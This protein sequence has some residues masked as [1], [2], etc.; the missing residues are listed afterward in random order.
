MRPRPEGR[1]EQRRRWAGLILQAVELQCGHDPKA[2]E[3]AGRGLRFGHVR[4]PLQCGHDP[5]AV[6]NP[7]RSRRPPSRRTGFNAATTRRPWRTRRRATTRRGLPKLQCGH[8]PKAVENSSASGRP[9]GWGRRFNAATTRRPWRTSR[10]SLVLVGRP[11]LQCGHDPKAVENLRKVFQV[12]LGLLVASMR[13]RP[14]GRGE[15]TA[16]SGRVSCAGRASMRPRPEGRGERLGQ[17]HEGRP[18]RVLQCG[19]DP[20]AVENRKPPPPPPRGPPPLQCGHNPKAVENFSSPALAAVDGRASMRPRP[21]GRGEPRAV[22]RPYWSHS[23]RFNAATTRRPWR[24]PGPARLGSAATRPRFNAATTRRP[25]RTKGH[26]HRLD[27]VAEG[28]NAATTRRPWRTPNSS[29]RRTG[30]A[31]ASMRPRPEGRGERRGRYVRST[32][33][34]VASMRPRPEGRGEARPW[35]GLGRADTALQCGHDPEAVERPGSSTAPAAQRQQ[36]SMRPRPEG[37][38]EPPTSPSGATRTA[39][40]NAATTRRP[41]RTSSAC[42]DETRAGRSFNAATT[43]R[44][45]RTRTGP[46]RAAA[47]GTLQCGHDPKAVENQPAGARPRRDPLQCGHDPKAVENCNVSKSCPRSP[48][49]LQCGHDPKAVENDPYVGRE[50]PAE[51]LQCGHDP[52]AVENVR[53]L[54]GRAAGAGR[55]NAATTR[56]PWRTSPDPSA[57]RIGP[58]TASMRPRPEGRGEPGLLAGPALRLLLRASMRPRPEGRGEPACGR[59][60]PTTRASRFNAATTRRPWRTRRTA[61]ATTGPHARFNAATTRRPW[62]TPGNGRAISMGSRPLQCGHDPKAVEN[63]A[64]RVKT[65]PMPAGASMRPRPEGRGERGCFF[66]IHNMARFNAATTRRPWRT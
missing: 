9:E 15:P 19:H 23:G 10:T 34:H 24:T 29:A 21:E 51:R 44:P 3:N 66:S 48:R 6:E 42:R 54:R 20:K 39:G 38:G 26:R 36:A 2:V 59:P 53:R 47:A 25:W 18:T 4:H 46:R 7:R 16:Y 55:F 11:A 12:R 40:F 45:W 50:D 62:R 28:F 58:P 52:K 31:H 5:K 61:T 8:D 1:G 22:P 41:W 13:P 30:R 57:R 27:D 14:E 17:F 33:G 49:A 32:R 43:R 37:R 65:S 60:R 35:P 56:R 63:L 64:M